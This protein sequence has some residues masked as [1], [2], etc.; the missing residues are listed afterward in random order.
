AGKLPDPGYEK[1]LRGTYIA[2]QGIEFLN[3]HKRH[4]FALWV[5]FNEPHSPFAFPVEDR[6]RFD[7]IVSN[8]PYVAEVDEPSLQPEVRD[9]EP[10]EALFGGEDGLDVLRRLAA[11]ASMYLKAGGL[12]ALEVGFGQTKAV[13]DLLEDAGGYADVRVLRDYAGKER[14]VL[15]HGA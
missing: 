10:R 12:L 9:W 3:D 1:D 8:P 14:F 2:S 6:E 15:A 7:V 4:P 11:E 5:S 13:V